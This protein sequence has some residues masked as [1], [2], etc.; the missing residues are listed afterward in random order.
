MPEGR[1]T[2]LPTACS[3]SEVPTVP[4]PASSPT[5][6]AGSASGTDAQAT[7]RTSPGRRPTTVA[8]HCVG[9]AELGAVLQAAR[10]AP[11]RAALRLEHASFVPPDWVPQVRDVRAT[12]VTQPSF[13]EAHGDRYLDDPDLEP[14][15]WL[16]RL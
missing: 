3:S 1:S 16:Y 2:A 11:R 5:T 8:G 13:V 9:P 12:V 6:S 14:H 10:A 15:D 7:P 4:R